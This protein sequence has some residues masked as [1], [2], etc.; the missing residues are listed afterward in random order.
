MKLYLRG[1]DYRYAAEQ[2]HLTLFPGQR[3]EYPDDPPA[4]GE[5]HL[6]L[7]LSRG[8]VWATAHAVLTWGGEVYDRF[9]RVPDPGPAGKVERDRALQRVLKDAF[10]RAGTQALGKEPPWGALTGVRPV[11]IPTKAM[12]G[13]PPPAQAAGP[14]RGRRAQVTG[15]PRSSPCFSA[16]RAWAMGR[17]SSA[18][19]R[20]TSRHSAA[21]HTEGREHL[22]L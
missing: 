10:Y 6:V 17:N 1:H 20:S 4:E 13:G 16:S 5:D 7:S 22:A 12:E 11:K 15:Q 14:A 9:A 2:M 21:L 8:P 18:T 3:P 19:A